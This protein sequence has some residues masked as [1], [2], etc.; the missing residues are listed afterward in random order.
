MTGRRAEAIRL[1]SS[2]VSSLTPQV[3]AAEKLPGEWLAVAA[4]YACLRDAPRALELLERAFA[5][6]LD[7]LPLLLIGDPSF[8]TLRSEP[9]FQA[10]LRKMNLPAQR[11]G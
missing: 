10:L 9:R 1:V 5:D 7:F 6:R 8:D 3:D 11:V 4:A 2:L